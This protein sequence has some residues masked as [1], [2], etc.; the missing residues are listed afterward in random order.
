M[1]QFTLEALEQI[2]L[3]E[4]ILYDIA[5]TNHAYAKQDCPVKTGEL[6]RS[7]RYTIDPD[8]KA[9]IVGSDSPYCEFIEYGTGP[10]ERAHG[11]HDPKHPV[12]DWEAK[13]K[14]GKN[15]LAQMPFLR[16]AAFRTQKFID[17]FIPK[18]IKMNVSVVVK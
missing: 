17:K 6:Q 11:P 12:R 7:I 8:K 3:G 18:R 10:M 2:I 1:T 13:R 16:P 5:A 9:I 14:T 15:M 4:G